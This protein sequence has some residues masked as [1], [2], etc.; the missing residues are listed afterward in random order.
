MGIVG[1]FFYRLLEQHK[2]TSRMQSNFNL[3][4]RYHVTR[5]QYQNI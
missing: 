1:V 3:L 5:K 4:S 2:T